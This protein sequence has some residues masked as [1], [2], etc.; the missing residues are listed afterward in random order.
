[1]EDVNRMSNLWL[2]QRPNSKAYIQPRAP[3][4]FLENEKRTFLQLISG[5]HV[6]TNYSSMLRKHVG[7]GKLSALKSFD[8]H[9]LLQ[10]IMPSAIKHMLK[11]GPREAIIKIGDFFQ[12]LCSKVIDPATIP[13]L[14]E[15]VGEAMCLF[16]MWFPPGFF[17]IMIYLPLHLVEELYWCG[18]VPI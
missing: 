13:N 12:Q 11:P 16:E 1:M 10:Q 6:P 7:K 5:T 15:C 2:Q 18:P 4:V 9:I 17:D 14:L 8:H 3:Y